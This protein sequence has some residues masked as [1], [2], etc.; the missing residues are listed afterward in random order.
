MQVVCVQLG[1]TYDP[2][3]GVAKTQIRSG[4]T[5]LMS[6]VKCNHLD[7]DLTQCESNCKVIQNINSSSFIL[8]RP[9]CFKY[10]AYYSQ[11]KLIKLIYIKKQYQIKHVHVL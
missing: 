1:L 10:N 3:H 5:I 7:T 9:N 4:S 2:A 11:K 8:L 6:R